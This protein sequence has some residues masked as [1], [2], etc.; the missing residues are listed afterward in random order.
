MSKLINFVIV[1]VLIIMIAN[2]AGVIGEGDFSSSNYVFNTLSINDPEDFPLTQLF[3]FI[4]GISSVSVGGVAI[5]AFFRISITDVI[6]L[7]TKILVVATLLLIGWDF[8]IIILKL[9]ELSNALSIIIGTPILL[10]Y[11]F[12]I[13]EWVTE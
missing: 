2:F 10:Y 3:I 5:G 7:Q 4:A 11:G 6:K 9:S 12:Q 8:F 1:F 13:I